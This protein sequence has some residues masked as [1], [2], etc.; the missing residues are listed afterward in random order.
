LVWTA[1]SLLALPALGAT[2]S[3]VVYA[4]LM[5]AG[6]AALPRLGMAVQSVAILLLATA[7]WVFV[8]LLAARL[9]T[10]WTATQ[11]AAVMNPAMGMGCLIAVSLVALFWL[12]RA[13]LVSALRRW[14]D[15]QTAERDAVLMVSALVIGLMTIGISSEIDRLV[16]RRALA[17][18]GPWHSG[19]LKQLLFSMVWP[20]AACGQLLLARQVEP[21]PE[22]RAAWLRRFGWVPVLVAIKYLLVDTLY[23]R[24]EYSPALVGVLLNLQVV[25]ALIVLGSLVAVWFLAD[26]GPGDQAYRKVTTFL[27]VLLLLWTGCLEIDR[28]FVKLA[29][30]GVP[31]ANADLARQVALSIYAAVFAIA[32]VAAG[33]RVRSTALRYFGLALFAFTL[34]KVVFVDLAHAG[35]GYR[36]LSFMG[37]GLLLLGTSVLYGKLSPRL[38]VRAG[39]PQEQR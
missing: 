2:L 22:G 17:G 38:L 7:K 5:M 33:F 35:Q 25:A 30:S 1:A 14:G 21:S 36:V 15:G 6:D 39:E 8:D 29:A 13:A 32:S 34:L 26:G 10:H 16:E 19:Q 31:A 9:S 3:L 24:A 12:R 28:A 18:G 11:Y 20:L 27:C 23:Y 37:L 4:W